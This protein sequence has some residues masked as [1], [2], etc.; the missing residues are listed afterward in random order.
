[1]KANQ[2]SQGFFGNLF[3]ALLLSLQA[4]SDQPLIQRKAPH[5][6]PAS[7]K[8]PRR[9]QSTVLLPRLYKGHRP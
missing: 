6:N 3:S 8:K 2:I 4:E 1:M 9:R 7:M 5:A